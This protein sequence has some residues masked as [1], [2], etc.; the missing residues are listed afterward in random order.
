M[1]LE[2]GVGHIAAVVIVVSVVIRRHRRIVAPPIFAIIGIVGIVGVIVR[3]RYY[4]CA[5]RY[6]DV[7]KNIVEFEHAIFVI[8]V[9]APRE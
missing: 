4:F 1:W 5:C 7:P 3:F 9:R 8:N 6:L 2:G